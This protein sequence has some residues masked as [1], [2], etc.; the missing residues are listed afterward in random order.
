[1]LLLRGVAVPAFTP[2]TKSGLQN[3]RGG[4]ALPLG[5]DPV[6]PIHTWASKGS[7]GLVGPVAPVLENMR[8]IGQGELPVQVL[9]PGQGGEALKKSPN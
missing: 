7:R 3:P 9:P 1:M 6:V 8:A 2:T 5:V 4:S